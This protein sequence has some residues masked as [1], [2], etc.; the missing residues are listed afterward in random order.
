[1]S[2]ETRSNLQDAIDAHLAD[3]LDVAAVMSKDWVLAA[4]VVSLEDA[5]EMQGRLSIQK[6]MGTSIFTVMGLLQFAT[7]TYRVDFGEQDT[8]YG[9]DYDE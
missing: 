3:E 4:H 6:G 2:Y 7:D 9:T 8:G 1:M 5:N